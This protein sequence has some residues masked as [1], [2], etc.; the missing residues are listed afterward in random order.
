MLLGSNRDW[1][2]QRFTEAFAGRTSEEWMRDLRAADVPVGPVQPRDG[3]L[4]SP[5]LASIGAR[6]EVE[7]PERG[8]VAMPATPVNLVATPARIR[9]PAP[10]LGGTAPE[11]PARPAPEGPA[12]VGQ[13]PLAGVRVLDLGTIL[14][15][16]YAGTL[17]AELGADVIKVEVPTGDSWRERGMPYIR[18]QRGLAVDLRSPGGRQAFQALVGTADVVIDNYRAGVLN[19]LGIDYETLR[20]IKPDVISVSITGFGEDSPFAGEPAFDPLLQA[21]SG[22][23]AAQGGDDEPVVLT[24]AVNDVTTAALAVLGTLLALLHRRRAGVGQKVWLSLAGTSTYAQ[25]EE[26]LGV[27]GRSGPLSGGRDFRGPSAWD[28]FYATADG[29]VRLQVP[30]RSAAGLRAAGLLDGPEPR[31][32][33]SSSSR[34]VSAEPSPRS[35]ET[36]RSSACTRPAS[37]RHQPGRWPSWWPTT[38]WR[39]PTCSTG[40]PWA[41]PRCSS[42]G[43]ICSSPDPSTD[44]RCDPRASANIPKRCSPRPD[45]APMRSRS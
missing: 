8:T 23:M 4:D 39:P 1:V 3:W 31:A 41:T 14:A 33:S 21:R 37:R 17:L 45:S 42:P 18:G 30:D 22:M 24:V 12:P 15:G 2:R 27:A 36:R 43:A 5:L 10:R 44:G 35:V 38:R 7:D 6:V 9:Q 19:R 25:C 11:W 40:W 16:P 34:S 26:L 29:W 28:R 20:T 13:P 32:D